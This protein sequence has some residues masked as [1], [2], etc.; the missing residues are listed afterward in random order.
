MENTAYGIAFG[1]DGRFLMVYHLRRKGWEMP[2]GRIEAG[3]TP[4]EAVI[5][6]FAEEAGYLVEVAAVR[7]LE[8]CRVCACRLLDKLPGT[9]EMKTGLFLELPEELSFD[10]AEYEDTVPWARSA[11]SV[12]TDF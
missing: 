5:R 10:R 1:G 4:E 8:H 2:G 12:N 3:E 7:N 9:C 11:I 6:E